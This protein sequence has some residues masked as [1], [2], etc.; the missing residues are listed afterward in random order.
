VAQAFPLAP[1]T[2]AAAAPVAVDEASGVLTA[3]G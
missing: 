1:V 3:A 2:L